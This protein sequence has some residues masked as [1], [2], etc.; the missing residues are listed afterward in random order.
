MDSFFATWFST[1]QEKSTR[2]A[3]KK[4]KKKTRSITVFP[5]AQMKN[6]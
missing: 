6:G 3:K 5:A 2:T 4:K 1:R